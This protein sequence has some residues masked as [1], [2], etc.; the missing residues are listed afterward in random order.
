MSSPVD[1][2]QIRVGVESFREAFRK[3]THVGRHRDTSYRAAVR[4]QIRD[5]RARLIGQRY[6]PRHAKAVRR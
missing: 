5:D 6:A 2:L 3:L 4:G 1:L